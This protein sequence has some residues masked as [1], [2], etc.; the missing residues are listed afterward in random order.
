MPEALDEEL[1]A[2]H[3]ALLSRG[4]AIQVPVYE[5]PRHARAPHTTRL[6][7]GGVVIIE[8]LFTFYWEPV[9][10]RLDARIFIHATEETCLARRL[11][12]DV[13]ERGR[14]P[15]SIYRQW[16]AAVRPMYRRYVE[17][18]RAHATLVVS[19]EDPVAVS[20]A[21]ICAVVAPEIAARGT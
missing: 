19:G 12:R 5:F 10:N 15:E 20:V 8:G 18:T 21:A 11:E 13:R 16:E 3:V 4:E 2:E 6:A 14:S 7:P 17:P 9:R 1:I